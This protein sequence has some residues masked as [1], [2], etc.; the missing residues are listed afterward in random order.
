[1]PSQ[2]AAVRA[3]IYPHE[4]QRLFTMFPSG[5]PGLA[6]FLLRIGVAGGIW[7]QALQGG[8][9]G[10]AQL[11]GMSAVSALLVAGYATPLAAVVAAAVQMMRLLDTWRLGALIP[12]DFILA[13]IH[14]TPALS[15]A[16]LGP[17][18]FSI[19]A[20]LFGRKIVTSS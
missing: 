13:A 7:E 3:R 6:L 5:G 8:F 14:A 19:D 20:R 2:C 9:P 12:A 16:L 4:V 15:L 11:A 10:V 1:M 18:A 17:G